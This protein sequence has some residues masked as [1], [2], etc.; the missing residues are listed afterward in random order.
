M[1]LQYKFAG[2]IFGVGGVFLLAISLIYF[3]QT[4]EGDIHS[5]QLL[6]E[7]TALERAEHI[8]LT[9][10]EKAH[11]A[12]VLSR[13]HV[14][15]SG[16]AD[17]NRRFAA[18]D[19][20]KRRMEIK[21]LDAAWIQAKNEDDPFV[22]P[23][24]TNTVAEFFKEHERA[25]PGEYGEIFLT[26]KYG[27]IIATTK[28]L[29]TLAHAHKYW[30]IATYN[31]GKGR[32]F[33]DDRGYDTSAKGYV[34]GV[35]VP[36]VED[37]E[38]IGILKCNH[39]ITATLN[40]VVESW[41]PGKTGKLMIV[42]G[43]GKIVLAPGVKPLS[44]DAPST[45]VAK[46]AGRVSGSLI[47]NEGG[48]RTLAAYAPM[49]IENREGEYGFGGTAD[50]LDHLMG[51]R[52]ELWF[53][54][55]SQSLEEAIAQS[56]E[57]TREIALTGI[58]LIA[59]MGVS[60]MYFGR[61]I[62]LPVT[63]M[64][65][66]A[67]KIGKGDYDV[68]VDAPPGDEMGNLA[69]AFNQMA[70]NLRTTTG[71]RD[72]LAEEVERR[73]EAEE[74]LTESEQRFRQLA[75]ATFEGIAITE[76][77]RLLDANKPFIG[78][79]GYEN[80]EEV[81]GKN[82]MEFAAPEYRETVAANIAAGYEKPYEIM[83]MRK[84]GSF[85]PIEIRARM[86]EI[87]GRKIRVTALRDMTERKQAEKALFES[88]NK[89]RALVEE[90]SDWVWE[91]DEKGAFTYSSPQV[92]E[93][94]GYGAEEILEKTPFDYMRPEEARRVAEFFLAT[95]AT[96]KPFKSFENSTLHKDGYEVV[97][98]T[99]GTPYFSADGRFMGYRGINRDITE[100]KKAEESL[101][102]K[103]NDVRALL[104]AAQESMFLMEVG[105]VVIALN[106]T[107]AKRFGKTPDE[108]VG[109]DIYDFMPPELASVRRQKEA[110]AVRNRSALTVEDERA[111]RFIRT[112]LWPVVDNQTGKVVRLAAFSIDITQTRK[113]ETEM[114]ENRAL[115][116]LTLDSLMD[117]VFVL[118]AATVTIKEV[119]RAATDIFGYPPD[120]FM[121]RTTEFLHVSPESL[122]AFRK[123]LYP[124]IER[125]GY[126]HLRDFRMKRR[127]GSTFPT[128]ISVIPIN[129]EQGRRV[130]W[131]SV[132]RDISKALEAEK[133]LA[134]SESRFREIF[135]T[136]S[137]AIFIHD[138]ETGRIIDVNRRMCGMYGFTREE[139]TACGPD[140]LSSGEPPYSAA[141]AF[142]KI[143][144]ARAGK[145]QT[146]EWLARAR[147]GHLFWVEV[148]LRLAV[149][150]GQER[151]LAVVR[152]ITERRRAEEILR[153]SE[154]RF[155]LVADS[156]PV[157]IWMAGPDGK[158]SYFNKGWLD[159]TG[160]PMEDEMGDGWAR[161]VHPH[162]RTWLMDLYMGAL[163]A[164]KSFSIE[165]RLRRWDGQYRWILDNGSPRLSSS[166]DF[167]GYIGSA[168]DITDRKEAESA[169]ARSEKKIRD[170]TAVIGQG[171]Y[172]LDAEGHLTF[173][174]PEAE[175][176]LGWNEA[177]LLGLDVHRRFHGKRDDGSIITRGECPAHMA[178]ATGQTQLADGELFTKK[179]G[180]M[181]PASIVATPM[182]EEG[183]VLGVVVAFSDIT[184]R[185]KIMREITE[186]KERAEEATKL[187]DKFVSLVA[188]DLKSPFASI[189]GL[190]EVMGEDQAH[191][192]DE[193]NR[194]IITHVLQ[195]GHRLLH[196]I[197]ELL[198]ISRLKTGKIKP[199]F[200]F[201]DGSVLAGMALARISQQ[202]AG[203][204][205][206]IANEVPA[207]T[208]LYADPDL[209]GEVLQN[210]LT[211]A[212]KFSE[213][214][215][216][217]TVFSPGAGIIAVKDVGVGIKKSSL[218]FLFRHEEK[219]TTPG[220]AGELG[221]GLGLPL[222]HDMMTAM[223][224]DLTVESE[225]GAGSVFYAS[226]PRI[227]PV[228][229]I[230][231]DQAPVRYLV[232]QHLI[233]I[234][235]TT[236]EAEDG[237]QALQLINRDRPHL[238]ITDIM[239][240]K[241]SGF[242]LLEAIR[243]NPETASI[244]VMMIT[245][246][247]QVESREKSFRMGADDFV[248]KPIKAEDFIP[249]VRRFLG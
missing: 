193:R 158:C 83:G 232:K 211:N 97:V 61:R 63:R 88:E 237:D 130:A 152:D 12:S 225:E 41:R 154:N 176:L 146:F 245:A 54:V 68:H 215:D 179:D 108:M 72:R 26:N 32:V 112:T 120:E 132:V 128:E 64:E 101:R 36:V 240:P 80:V 49:R 48:V 14:V 161:G 115:L 75:E 149:I 173:M 178:L 89:Y 185:Q 17:S 40:K 55:I 205:V 24:M 65:K 223:G 37:G 111:G 235:V 186:T 227:N 226:L 174:N 133:A 90:T 216:A 202:A 28:K 218:P 110:E 71:S 94:T 67:E 79:F 2:I 125:Q 4:H 234:G 3:F 82:A 196:M 188:H 189:I 87:T 163:E 141:E 208:R 1:K 172:A 102:Q 56:Y 239:M 119:N 8:S 47:L 156:A 219:T 98:E 200:R 93:I 91:L 148:S 242:D 197:D 53:V 38:V 70:V 46:L 135:N 217:V 170:I 13:S 246:D 183:R 247:N 140:D 233:R 134:E 118:D 155:R 58:I 116:R 109:K 15:L 57:R 221:T 230:V 241:I 244:P 76:S 52:G 127:D 167:I 212:V 187:K 175:R 139:A 77:G 213:K 18:L 165:Y 44:A 6:S 169:L 131:V 45:L 157:L 107:A 150:G 171:V 190:L 35:T 144:L 143:S 123:E 192:L 23:Y 137:D 195:S 16:L 168:F 210:L 151:I 59:L 31:G 22:R 229:L 104:D 34:I 117:A 249:R 203:K 121:G 138:A 30:W 204:G 166:G 198:D 162:D 5:Q 106:E 43:K 51:N 42:R 100:R 114:Q 124:A 136:V 222:S 96:Q 147:D 126:L 145:P 50:S 60:A 206:S 84:D 122:E 238:V 86:M 160:R 20:D 33:F 236:V 181:F 92:R 11:I 74:K 243:K 105:G 214:G 21:R 224:G 39:G 10:K 220:T 142:E 85:F 201:F 164:R 73:K 207:G 231:D 153:E 27:A 209:F 103:T 81:V 9:L 7:K 29:T 25:F 129:D 248:S 194:D 191:V 180:G 199:E 19:D 95:S 78:M 184:E 177:E 113:H 228:A 69:I 66:F 62:A 99:S 159:F 182:M